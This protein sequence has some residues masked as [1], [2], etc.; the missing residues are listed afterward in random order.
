MGETR[1][2]STAPGC[3]CTHGPKSGSLDHYAAT[4][5]THGKQTPVAQAQP[6]DLLF[7]ATNT[8]D[9]A[10]IH[11]VTVYVGDARMIE[12]PQSGQRVLETPVRND[13][14]LMAMA[15]QPVVKGR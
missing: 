8:T 4:H 11:H 15:V 3:R 2:D 10:S 12:A 14:E 6:G 13:G 9:A 1:S 7:Y 5:Y